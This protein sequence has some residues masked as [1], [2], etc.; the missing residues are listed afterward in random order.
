MT[1]GVMPRAIRYLPGLPGSQPGQGVRL[2]PTAVRQRQ[3]AGAARTLLTAGLPAQEGAPGAAPQGREGSSPN[4]SCITRMLG[5][6]L[7]SAPASE[8]A[9]PDL[10]GEE[11]GCP[12][13]ASR[14]VQP[15]LPN[16]DGPRSR[17]PCAGLSTQGAHTG[18]DANQVETCPLTCPPAATL[19][20]PVH[21]ARQTGAGTSLQVPESEAPGWGDVLS[22]LRPGSGLSEGGSPSGFPPN[23]FQPAGCLQAMCCFCLQP[24]AVQLA[25]EIT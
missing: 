2:I 3:G 14:D 25:A 1:A 7:G 6:I 17:Q 24:L 15:E 11:L 4:P 20:R 5:D 21:G 22:P 23:P 10:Q 19:G 9:C 12:A 8:V 13:A 18:A 16:P